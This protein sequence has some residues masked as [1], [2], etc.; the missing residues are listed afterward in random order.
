MTKNNLHEK[1]SNWFN[2]F[3]PFLILFSLFVQGQTTRT[4]GSGTALTAAI[5][6]STTGDIVKITGDI[7][8]ASQITISGKTITIDGQ[9]FEI[10]VPRPGLDDMGRYNSSPSTYRVM[11]VTGASNITV[12]DITLKGGFTSLSGGAIAVDSGS[13]LRL[14]NSI[15]TSSVASSGGGIQIAGVLFMK[16]SFVRRNAASYGGGILVSGSGRAYIEESTMIENRSTSPSG[17]GGAAECQSGSVLYFNNS[18]LSNNQSTEIGGAINNYRGTVYFINSTATGN[19]AFGGYS[20]GAIGNNAGNVWV[21]NSLFAHN[22]RRTTGT[23]ANPTGYVLDDIEPFSTSGGIRIYHSIYHATLPAGLDVNTGNIQYTGASNGSNNTI[24]SGGLI[25]KITDN[26]GLEI[27]DALFRPFLYF[28]EGSIAP[29]LKVGS[30]V[31]QASNLGVPTRFSN[32]NNSSPAIALYSGSSWQNLLGTSSLGQEVSSDQLGSTRSAVSPRR[33]AVETELNATL[34]IVKVNGATGGTVT[35]GTIYGDVYAA[36]STATIT[37]IPN[38]GQRFVRWDYV[39]GGTGTASTS[40]PYQFTVNQNVTLVPVFTAATAGSYSLTYVGNGN[41]DGNAPTGSVFTGATTIASAGTLVNQGYTFAGWN[42]NSNGSGTQYLAGST[43]SAGSNLTLYAMWQSTTSYPGEILSSTANLSFELCPTVTTQTKSF[44]LSANSISSSL[45]LSALAGFTYSLNNVNFSPT[46]TINPVSGQISSTTVYVRYTSPNNEF[47]GGTISINATGAS[48]RSLIVTSAASPFK[49]TTQPAVSSTKVCKR[50]EAQTI[51]VIANNASGYQWYRNTVNST[52]GATLITGATSPSLVLSTQTLGTVY[53]FVKVSSSTCP[54]IDSDIVSQTVV[55]DILGSISAITGPASVS[56]ESSVSYSVNLV[57]NAESYIWNLPAGMSITN[58]SGNAITVYADAS[59]VGGTVTVKA[60]NTC[61]VSAL[62]SRSVSLVGPVNMSITGSSIVCNSNFNTPL[63]YTASTVEGATSYNWTLPVGAEIISFPNTNSVQIQ[64]TSTFTSGTIKVTA[65]NLFATLGVGSISVGG[66]QQPGVITGPVIVCGSSTAVYSIVPVPDATSY[67]WALPS[68]MSLVGSSSGN[69]ITVSI[70]GSVDGS[71]NV[72]ANGSCGS[73]VLRSL[74]VSSVQRPGVIV[75][76]RIVCGASS[77]IIDVNGS[78]S[79]NLNSNL[80]Y[81]ILPVEGAVSYTWTAPTGVTIV[82]GQGTTSI[83]A[84]V[85]YSQFVPGNLN[86]VANYLNCPSSS[87]RSLA[88]SS[89]TSVISG[90]TNICGLTTATYS[91]PS[92]IGTNFVWNVPSWMTIVSGSG[93]SSIVVSFSNACLGDAISVG[94]I[95]T[96]NAE[97]I[98]QKV[99]GCSLYSKVISTQCES[100]LPAINSFIFAVS[101]PQATQ[102]KF[103]VNDG[104]QDYE[105][106]TSNRYFR[107]T[108]L[109]I[110]INFNVSYLVK[111]GVLVNGSWLIPSCECYVS[112]PGLP[113]TQ[114]TTAYCNST[115]SYVNSVIQADQVSQVT[116]YKFE[117]TYGGNIY[118]FTTTNRW[119]RL[120]DVVGLPIQYASSYSVR[121]AVFKG[122]TWGNY[123]TSC[124]VTTPG[125]PSTNISK[126]ICGTS[127]AYINSFIQ[128]NA[129]IGVSTYKFKVTGAGVELDYVTSNNWFRLTDL[130]GVTILPSSTYDVSVAVQQGQVW[131]SFGDICKISTPSSTARQVES[132]ELLD[133]REL[134]PTELDIVVYPNPYQEYFTIAL[135]TK[136]SEKVNIEI[137]NSAGVLV[138]NNELDGDKL[139]NLSIGEYFSSGLYFLK[140]KS[141]N[142]EKSIRIIKQ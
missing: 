5:T 58:S 26:S 6:A 8:I 37:A 106:V 54:S 41:T 61:Y 40:N 73:S 27:G 111:V 142:Y 49:I 32:N 3:V 115:L 17:G 92:N 56:A 74:S 132:K 25:S 119:F 114:L 11:Q 36:G 43:Y 82:S 113:V 103:I 53:Y 135:G 101:V 86:V 133:S 4:A 109:G 52:L 55:N 65:T 126:P 22:Y 122:N 30:F 117:V 97:V 83:Q 33:G 123:G 59:F 134:E 125:I 7:V 121:V 112:T 124:Q 24:F 44:T 80:T 15:V 99:I 87:P 90:P 19:V 128:A 62:R 91:V 127:L 1:K 141:E 130:P 100:T 79:T 71:L 29:T 81:T 21:L 72:I 108:D 96:C 77:N 47:L 88:L 118:E 93:T 98:L 95:S 69:E 129:V 64:F 57:S 16:K 9:G 78:V 110:S 42:T 10:S 50:S 63:T 136:S 104:V 45:T 51:Q 139:D 14:N 28:N 48:T 35:G 2:Y 38:S 120:T 66:L 60:I 137:Y 12:N 131:S 76:P 107:L 75:G 70:T 116:Q 67:S 18:T 84:S 138:Y 20:G 89:S 85:D 39:S 31:N 23:V 13:T 34:Y 105:F 68:G 46:L 140:V 94:Y 102:Y